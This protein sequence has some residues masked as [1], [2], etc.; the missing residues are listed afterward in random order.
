MRDEKKARRVI[1]FIQMLHLASGDFRGK[2]FVLQ[3]WQKQV[4]SDFYGEVNQ[5]EL[6][7]YRARQYL[8]LE[9]PKKNG[10]TELTAAIGLYHLLA[11]NEKDPQIYIC[12]ADR[13][14]AAICYNAMVGMVEQASW[15]NQRVKPLP[16]GKV[17]R[18]KQGTGFV[19]VLS[20]EAET[21]HGLNPSC[22]IFDELHAQPNRRLWDVMTYGAGSARRQPCWM[23]L[24]TAGDDPDRNSIGWEIHEKC[25]RIL[26]ARN[27]TGDPED[28]NPIWLPI[29]YGM[30][31]DPEQVAKIDIYDETLW[32]KLNPSL[33][34]SIS[35]RALRNEARDA[36]KSEASERLFRWL[37]LNQDSGEGGGLAAADAVR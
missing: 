33:G 16:S 27:G 34:I 5:D 8:Y 36:K 10:K 30:P 18:L 17:L 21:K 28:D 29:I 7:T 23:V 31:D 14:N 22:V 35:L 4:I 25:T 11:D 6:G 9:I 37:R 19:K 2:P 13:D 15:M 3:D 26:A 20:S 1:N 12:A 32:Q 24:T